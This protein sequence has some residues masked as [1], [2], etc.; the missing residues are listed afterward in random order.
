VHVAER[1]G[2]DVA[3]VLAE[4]ERLDGLGDVGDGRV[5]RLVGALVLH[6]VLFAADHAD[7]DLEDGV[8]VLEAGEEVLRDLDVLVERHGRAVPHVGLED[9]VAARLDLLLGGLDERQHEV[10]QRRLGAVVGV[11]G[12]RDGVGLGDLGGELREGEGAVRAGLDGVAGEVVGAAR[13][14]LDDA[15]GTGLGEALEDRV[16]RLRAGDVDRRV[17]EAA[18]FRAVQH[19]G[20]LLWGGDGHECSLVVRIDAR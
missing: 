1:E 3:A 20:V 4:P 16:D 8:D 2:R 15:V 5:E 13:R 11:Q 19:V 12:H 17:R 10:G 6:A 7:L 14:D 18:G 9:R